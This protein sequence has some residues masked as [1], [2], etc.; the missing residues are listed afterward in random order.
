MEFFKKLFFSKTS[1]SLVVL[2]A[3]LWIELCPHERDAKLEHLGPEKVTLFGKRVFAKMSLRR[4]VRLEWAL[5]PMT[6]VLIKSRKSGH[7]GRRL[8]CEDGGRNWGCVVTDQGTLRAT[9]NPKR[10]G[11]GL[12]LKL[13][14]EYSPACLHLDL[15]LPASSSVRNYQYISVFIS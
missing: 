8:P 12:P 11:R 4:H 15:R 9:R 13:W 10:Q 6:G 5:S 1:F 7:I 14:R 3:L 2:A